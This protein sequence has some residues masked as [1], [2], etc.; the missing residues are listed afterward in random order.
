[1]LLRN[2]NRINVS[3][4]IAVVFAFEFWDKMVPPDLDMK[5]IRKR[6]KG[7]NKLKGTFSNVKYSFIDLVIS[8]LDNLWS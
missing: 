4:K 2:F 3:S 1:M 8:S 5:I 6:R 7:E